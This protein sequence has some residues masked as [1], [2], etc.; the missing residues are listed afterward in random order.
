MTSTVAVESA[1][2][3]ISLRISRIGGLLPMMGFGWRMRSL[4]RR[5]SGL[6]D[7]RDTLWCD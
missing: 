6:A 2:V 3:S 5:N 7:R 4:S 1:I